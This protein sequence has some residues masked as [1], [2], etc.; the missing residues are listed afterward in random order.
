M[1]GGVEDPPPFFSMSFPHTRLFVI[2]AYP[3]ICH[4]RIPAYLSF[5]PACRQASG[6]NALPF[7]IPA[8]PP[9][10][11]MLLSGIHLTFRSPIPLPISMVNIYSP[12]QPIHPIREK[13]C[14]Y[15]F[16]N[17]SAISKSSFSHTDCRA[18]FLRSRQRRAGAMTSGCCSFSLFTNHRSLS[19]TMP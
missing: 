8:C 2:P 14:L 15:T 11:G 18:L 4:S 13:K 16:T 5:L 10:E 3:S 12:L 17:V 19:H 9:L 7:V 6:G 1:T